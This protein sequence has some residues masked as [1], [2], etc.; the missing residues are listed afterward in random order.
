MTRCVGAVVYAE[1]VDIMK[2][3]QYL[4][5]VACLCVGGRLSFIVRDWSYRLVR[6]RTLTSARMSVFMTLHTSASFHTK[7]KRKEKSFV[8]K[9]QSS[10]VR[11]PCFCSRWTLGWILVPS[12]HLLFLICQN[13]H[14]MTSSDQTTAT[15]KLTSLS[16]P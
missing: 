5:L 7:K 2:P 11:T 12:S 13:S 9:L 3:F 1:D 14:S 8:N 16:E 6:T 15:F 10:K 4:P